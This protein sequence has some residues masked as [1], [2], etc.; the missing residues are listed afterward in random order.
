LDDGKE[1]PSYGR[2]NKG[3]KISG[4]RIEGDRTNSAKN[5]GRCRGACTRSA[6][7]VNIRDRRANPKLLKTEGPLEEKQKWGQDTGENDIGGEKEKR[8]TDKT[9]LSCKT[10]PIDRA[11]TK[12]LIPDR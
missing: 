5:G 2:K 3:G 1:G 12:Q 7:G 8:V 10:T 11:E 6:Q 4:S 9:K